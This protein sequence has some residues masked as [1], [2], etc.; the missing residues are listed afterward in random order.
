MSNLQL[1]LT[2]AT[3]LLFETTEPVLFD[4]LS[5]ITSHVLR[6][7]NAP[8]DAK[9]A[10]LDF[11]SRAGREFC[12]KNVL[13]KFM[14]DKDYIVASI[15][16][17]TFVEVFGL[18]QLL[19]HRSYVPLPLRCELAAHQYVNR[20]MEDGRLIEML[21]NTSRD[22]VYRSSWRISRILSKCKRGRKLMASHPYF[23]SGLWS[24]A[25]KLHG[26]RLFLMKP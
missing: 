14:K 13:I 8:S 15:A 24:D 19:G 7:P 9:I 22:Y 6:I 4:V 1:P 20:S 12:K 16:L 23:K 3:L 18:S 11:Y 17:E 2:D 21:T 26:A 10:I 5:R 25:T